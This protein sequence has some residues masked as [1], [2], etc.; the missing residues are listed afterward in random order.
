MNLAVIG[1]G[2]HEHALCFKLKQSPKLNKLICIPGNAGTDEIAQN[3]QAKDLLSARNK[4]LKNI[5]KINWV[6]GFF[7]NDIG[8]KAIIKKKK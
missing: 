5:H 2:G 4:C 1:S 8:W 7:R 3:I 6:D